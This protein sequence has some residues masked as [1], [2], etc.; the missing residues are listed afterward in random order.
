V[1]AVGLEN[2]QRYEHELLVYGTERLL[3]VPGLRLLGTAADKAGV[4]SFVIDGLR[5]E[6]IGAALDQEG[7]AVRAGHHCAMPLHQKFHLPASTRASFYL[8]NTTA[9]VDLLATSVKKVVELFA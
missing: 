7:I 3:R 8:Y 9:E 4:F 6:E 5:T 1:S 2:I